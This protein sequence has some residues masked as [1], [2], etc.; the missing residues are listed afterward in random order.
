MRFL[1]R[2]LNFVLIAGIN[3]TTNKQF[4]GINDSGDKLLSLLLLLAK[5]YC[6]CH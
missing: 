1:C 5:N 2:F 3:A 6:H 4:T